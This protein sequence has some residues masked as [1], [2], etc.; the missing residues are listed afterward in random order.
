MHL[1]RKITNKSELKTGQ[2]MTGL[3]MNTTSFGSFVD[4]GLDKDALVHCSKSKG[5]QLQPN[6]TVEVIIDTIEGDRIGLRL[7][8]VLWNMKQEL[9]TFSKWT[10][11]RK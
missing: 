3:V 1:K 7:E 2:K 4:V 9:P 8:K 6:M 5:I 11:I 10:N